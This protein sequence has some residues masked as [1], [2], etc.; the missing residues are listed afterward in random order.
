MPLAATCVGTSLVA[1]CRAAIDETAVDALLTH[2]RYDP[3]FPKTTVDW[4]ERSIR[5]GKANTVTAAVEGWEKP[6]RHLERLREAADAPARLRAL[7]RSARALAEGAHREEAPLAGQR[8][9]EESQTPFSALE[10]RAGR[11]RRRAFRGARLARLA[12]RYAGARARGRHR[13]DRSGNRCALARPGNRAGAD[14]EPVSSTGGPRTGAVLR[15]PAGGRVSNLQPPRPA[16]LR[17]AARAHRQ[18]GP[19]ASR[20]GRRGALPVPR[21]RLPSDR[22]PRP[23]LAE[24]RRG[25]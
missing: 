21:V 20:P 22:A 5:R 19:A 18:P 14:H 16:A 11:G 4:L 17:G 9:N 6:P 2:L 13:G 15:R 10:L 25:R 24:L 7:A 12:V 23:Q 1:L 8:A 3:S